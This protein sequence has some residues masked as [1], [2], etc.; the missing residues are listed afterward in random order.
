MSREAAAASTAM[1]LAAILMTTAAKAENEIIGDTHAPQV[2]QAQPAPGDSVRTF[3]I[4]PQPLA[5]ALNAFGR[6]AGLQV[7]VEAS[8]A[9]G[10]QVQGVSGTMRPEQAL[11]QLL[12]GTGIVARFTPD[13]GFILSKPDLGGVMQLDPVQVQ[14]YPVPPQATI[15]NLPPP[16]A[17]GQMATGGQVGMLGNRSVMNTPF[18]VTNYTKK[19]I[20][21]QQAQTVQ[22]VLSNDPSI[23]TKQNS[24]SDED[25][26]I[27]IRGFRTALSSGSGSLNGLMGMSPL[28]SPDMD[29][30]ERVEVLKGPSALLNGMAASGVGGPGGSYNLVTKRAGDEPLAELT[31]RYGSSLQF[32]A[33]LDVGRRFGA[34]KQFGIRFNGAFRKGYTPVDPIYAEVGSAAINL[35]YRGERVRISADIAHQLNNA[36]PQITQQLVVSGVGGGVVFVPTAP[37]ARTSLNPAWSKQPSSLTLG[38]VQGEIDIAENVTAYAAF[39]KQKLNFSLIGPSQP[40]LL[41]TSGTYGWSGV[42][43]SKFAYDVLS[44]QSGVRARAAT[45]PANHAL[46]LNLSLS[47]METALAETTSPYTYTTNL[48]N[49]MFGPAPY[50]ADPGDPRKSSESQVSSIGVADTLSILGERVQFTAGIRYQAVGA[51]NFSTTTGAQ[52]SSYQG[53]AWSPALGLVVKPWENVSFYANYIQDLQRGA[54]VGPSYANSGDVLAPYVSKQYE[55]GVKV[56]WGTVTTTLAAFQIAQP[57]TV[58]ISSPT[59]GLPTLAL[60]GEQLNR[61]IELNA[62]GELFPGVRLMGGLTLL[63]ARLTKTQGG[64]YDGHR[65][66]GAPAVRTVVGGE[67]DTPFLQGL[68]LTGRFTYTGDQVVSGS[69]ENLKIPSWA[70]VDL[71]VRYVFDSPWNDKPITVRF[72]VDNVF[73]QDYWSGTNLRYIQLGAPRTFRLSTAF[74]F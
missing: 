73:D 1:T 4:P 71:G 6:Q 48:Y 22:D 44:V 9:S 40:K 28:R 72:N 7:S 12:A 15:G 50:I 5:S 41:D 38:M 56:D 65:A 2:A 20:E 33:H 10:V 13:R 68:T 18:S 31:A 53:K 26:S 25:G 46:S 69:N 19:T 47:R 34:E 70:L 29:Y 55:A 59:G 3:D 51:S 62:Y 23:L 74:K 11:N 37:N 66:D 14:G 35:D 67:W 64:L 61:G 27:N 30:I 39:G 21:D 58:S 16:Y 49:P 60:D 17:G 24:A 43:Y 32:G 42:E 57:N 54:I 52:T 45:G 63:D 36:N 8:V